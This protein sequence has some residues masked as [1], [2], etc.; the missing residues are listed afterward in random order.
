MGQ[1]KTATK[2]IDAEVLNEDEVKMPRPNV[3][4]KATTSAS[5]GSRAVKIVNKNGDVDIS[6]LSGEE[7]KKYVM[8]LKDVTPQDQS[9]IIHIGA[10][11]QRSIGSTGKAFLEKTRTSQTGQ[12]STLIESMVNELIDKV[13]IDDLNVD[14]NRLLTMLQK[15]P[16]IG[17]LIKTPIQKVKQRYETLQDSFNSITNGVYGIIKRCIADNNYLSEM[18]SATIEYLKD[19]DEEIVA[20]T[21]KIEDSQAERDAMNPEMVDDNEI[22]DMDNFITNLESKLVDLKA[23]RVVAKE[24]VKLM[25]SIINGNVKSATNS[26]SIINITLPALEQRMALAVAI[27]NQRRGIEAQAVIRKKNGELIEATTKQ[28]TEN[29]I[30]IEELVGH[31]AIDVEALQRSQEQFQRSIE[32]INQIRAQMKENRA[33]ELEICEQLDKQISELYSGQSTNSSLLTM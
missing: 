30:A 29:L 14:D 27:D 31:S 12:L 28:A 17:T 15:I 2:V 26:Q 18:K 6:L 32:K 3:R 8:R 21:I 19:L 25:G 5:S 13:G 11:T 9:S 33:K 23:A 4:R 7:R 1:R 16:I 22:A 24:N 20:L 10:D